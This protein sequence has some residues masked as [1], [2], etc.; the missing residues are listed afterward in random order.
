[1][2]NLLFLFMMSIFLFSCGSDNDSKEE[3][4]Y[5]NERDTAVVAD[6]PDST[7]KIINSNIF[8]SV[9]PN[10]Q[11][12]K[13]EL[14]KPATVAI[15]T[16]APQQLLDSLNYVFPGMQLVLN[17]VSHDTLYVRM[18]QST[19]LTNN[20]G[21]TGAENYLATIVYNLTELPGIKYVNLNFAP[22]NHAEP[23]VYSRHDF[24]K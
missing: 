24:K 17:K 16:F 3:V 20:I 8:W 22:G 19:R 14:K 13:R 4:V 7:L 15:N 23:G 6:N 9:Q 18:P 1:M 10:A 5:K 2:K 21:D 11:N 12:E